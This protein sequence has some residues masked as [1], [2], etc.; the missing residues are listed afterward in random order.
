MYLREANWINVFMVRGPSHVA[1]VEC[2]ATHLYEPRDRQ[3]K[4]ARVKWGKECPICRK[5][6][7]IREELQHLFKM[8]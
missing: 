1:K 7:H 6:D 3:V 4:P 2:L 5:H 8:H